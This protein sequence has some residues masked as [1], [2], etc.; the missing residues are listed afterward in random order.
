M[1]QLHKFNKV[2][3]IFKNKFIKSSI[4]RP[5][6]QKILDFIDNLSKDLF[7]YRNIKLYDDLV[8]FAYWCRKS[9]L[10]QIS[11]NYSHN[12]NSIG[13]G[14]VLHISPSNVPITCLYSFIFGILTGN[15]NAIKI[16]NKKFVQLEIFFEIL[17]K[18]LLK[19]KY[20]FL[21]YGNIFFKCDRNNDIIKYLS[22]N[23]NCRIIWGGDN[24]IEN[25]K[26]IKT[27]PRCVD[28]N[29]S[30]RYSISII[31]SKKLN[32]TFLK[33]KH[34]IIKKFYN[35]TYLFDQNGCSTPHLVLWYGKNNSNIKKK[36]WDELCDHVKKNFNIDEFIAYEKFVLQN[37]YLS[38]NY[39]SH[40]KKY[41]NYLHVLNI[42]QFPKNVDELRGKF[43]FFFEKDINSLGEI[44]NFVN[45]KFQTV[46]YF[47]FNKKKI[48]NYLVKNN[49]NGIDRIVPFGSAFNIGLIWDGY[50]LYHALSRKINIE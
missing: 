31:N 40:Y 17:K 14:L 16:P 22:L 36:F 8:S 29:F 13:R 46:T 1:I 5:F 35:D 47:G 32:N 48:L 11:T 25:F 26:H 50:D 18:I 30:D 44:L 24:T 20:N 37:I 28:I 21:N 9:N 19:K 4:T 15:N 34:N 6:D 12:I 49:I 41:E 23:A 43:G 2:D 42:K 27:N 33:N 39:I 38:K 3:F 45:F 7:K 10:K